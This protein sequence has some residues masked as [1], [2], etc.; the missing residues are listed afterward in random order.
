MWG[1]QTLWAVYVVCFVLAPLIIAVTGGNYSVWVFAAFLGLPALL[2]VVARMMGV[3]WL[4]FWSVPAAAALPWALSLA[5]VLTCV[6]FLPRNLQQAAGMSAMVP[7][8]GLLGSAGLGFFST[9]VMG[10]E[11]PLADRIRR[12]LVVS[13]PLAVVVTVFLAWVYYQ[14]IRAAGKGGAGA[15]EKPPAAEAEGRNPSSTAEDE[16]N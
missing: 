13:A 6:H 12:P 2:T 1:V 9:L 16:R 14:D 10:P 5:L 8:F 3:G 7:L 4:E 11:V 15:D